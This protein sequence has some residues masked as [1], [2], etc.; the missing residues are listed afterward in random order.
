[1]DTIDATVSATPDKIAV[2]Q[3]SVKRDI[4]ADLP[5]GSEAENSDSLALVPSACVIAENCRKE[6]PEILDRSLT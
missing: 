1:M 3:F 4:T 6:L 5:P 2:S